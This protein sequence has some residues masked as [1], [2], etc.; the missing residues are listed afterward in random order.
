MVT[1]SSSGI[2][3]A[4]ALRLARDGARVVDPGVNAT[5]RLHRRPEQ[6]AHVLGSRNIGPDGKALA[7]RRPDLVHDGLREVARSRCWTR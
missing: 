4:I 3:R 7:A 2:G 6:V 1:G 5:E